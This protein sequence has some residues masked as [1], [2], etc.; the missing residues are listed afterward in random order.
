VTGDSIYGGDR[1][2]RVW[3]EQQEQPF[4]LAV[5]SA[6]PLCALL[7]GHFGQPRAHLIAAHI[8]ANE[9]RRLSA[10]VG[11]KGPRS[12]DWARVRLA[13]LQLTAEERRWEHYLLVRRSR[14]DPTELAYYVVFAPAGTSL[15]TLARVAGQR[16]RVE[17]SFELAK[18]EVGLDHYEVRRSRRLVSAYDPGDVGLGLSR[19]A[20]CPIADPA[21]PTGAGAPH[22]DRG[23]SRQGGPISSRS[24]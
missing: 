4:V 16:W 5:T 15:R 22:R 13:R 9:W 20:A 12:Y 10:G 3:L 18:G 1:R 2:L 21:G 19:C 14:H 17:Q 23:R 11:A 24:T 6:E 7:A 8:P